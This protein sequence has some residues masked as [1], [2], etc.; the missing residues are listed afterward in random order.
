MTNVISDATA[1]ILQDRLGKLCRE[2]GRKSL[3][4][5]ANTYLPA[6]FKVQSSSMHLELI[7]MLEEATLKR[8]ARI[9]IAAPRGH[10]KS[11]LVSFAFV[12]WCIC[13]KYE[14]YIVLIS[15]TAGQSD[16]LLT[17]I[18]SEL[19]SNPFLLRDF[20]DVAEPRGRKPPPKR[21]RK[22]DIITRNGVKVLSLGT[23]Q[24]IRG[25]RHRE[26]RPTLIILDDVE[27]ETEMTSADQRETKMHW[28]KKAVMKSGSTAQ[29]NVVVVGTI[30]HYDSLLAQLIDG[31]TMPG[32]TNRKYQA[33]ILWATQEDLWQEWE[34]IYTHQAEYEGCN[35]PNAARLFY[36]A[37][38][39]Q[40]L[41][42]TSVLWPQREN[43]YQLMEIRLCE[44]HASFDSEKQNEPIDPASCYFSDSDMHYWD[45][46]YTSIDDLLM[47]LG[48]NSCI[49]GACDPS[50]GIAGKNRDDTAI[51]TVLK[52]TPTGHL[53]V[54]DADIRKRK[55][56]DIIKAIIEYHR[57]YKFEEFAIE[58]NQFQFFLST[59]V[60]RISAQAG[61]NVPVYEISHTSDKL[62]RIQSLEPLIS[63]GVLRFSRRQR[64]LLDQLQQFPKAAHDDAPDALEMA[65]AV[66]R[67]PGHI[68]YVNNVPLLERNRW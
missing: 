2:A 65:V 29:T 6:H 66:S 46:E 53:Y 44:G 19:E 20:P 51:V 58:T 57:I 5:F 36:E 23:G 61:V 38:E 4:I 7:S 34:S 1:H 24:K 30:L 42:G 41:E 64:I 9:A 31:K 3:Q 52:H 25:R 62:G 14:L 27:N 54:L 17:Q 56:R 55:P 60:T 39:E 8:N 43:Y 50:L 10:A 67:E 21:W 28:F 18:K 22:D 59:E 40:M 16:D 33:V 48:S 32:W 37:N 35:G 26:N 13:Y 63:T 15:N 12:L 47:K 49:Y 11:T 68:F 45:D